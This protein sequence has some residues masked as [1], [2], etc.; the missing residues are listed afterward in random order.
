MVVKRLVPISIA[1]RALS[2]IENTR[3]NGDYMC[4]C[5]F[6]FFQKNTIL[7]NRK[8]RCLIFWSGRFS[9]RPYRPTSPHNSADT[10]I[11]RAGSSSLVTN[12]WVLKN[13]RNNNNNNDFFINDTS[14]S[15]RKTICPSAHSEPHFFLGFYQIKPKEDI[16][17][18]INEYFYISS[19]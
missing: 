12:R 11:C 14:K 8:N 15:R 5:F 7:S 6:F 18:A 1:H 4:V 16:V 3:F 13:V 19:N 10:L 17:F 9:T 2:R